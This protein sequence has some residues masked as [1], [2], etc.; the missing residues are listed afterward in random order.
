[1]RSVGGRIIVLYSNL[2]KK[3]KDE[4]IEGLS[5]GV[6]G[7]DPAYWSATIIESG[8]NIDIIQITKL[9]KE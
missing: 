5:R 4:V 3:E 7:M 1:M 8:S 9:V 6:L 2:S